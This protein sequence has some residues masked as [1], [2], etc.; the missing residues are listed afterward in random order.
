MTADEYAAA[1][2]AEIARQTGWT[3]QQ[4]Q[5]MAGDLSDMQADDMDPSDAA[6]EILIAAAES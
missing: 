1:V 4:A 5:N 2:A 3:E 6:T